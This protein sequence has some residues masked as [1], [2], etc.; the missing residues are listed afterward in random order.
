MTK[1]NQG[2]WDRQEDIFLVR[3]ST[4]TFHGGQD[5]AHLA[6]FKEDFSVT[7]NGLGTPVTASQAAYKAVSKIHHYPPADFEPA[8]SDLAMFLWPDNNAWEQGRHRLLLGNGASELIDLVIR[9]AKP[10]LWRPGPQHTQYKEYARSALAAG[11][12]TTSAD[13]KSATLLCI[14]NPTNPTGE[15]WDLAK[16]KVYIEDSCERGTTVIV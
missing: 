15:Y 1:E 9:S 16:V 8:A 12:E 6:N 11:F 5:W 10:G 14:V 7:T 2:A 4:Q 3:N 13:D